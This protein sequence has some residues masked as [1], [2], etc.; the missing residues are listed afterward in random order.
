[1][2]EC[3]LINLA[4]TQHRQRDTRLASYLFYG[5]QIAGTI[6]AHDKEEVQISGIIGYGAAITAMPWL[7]TQPAKQFLTVAAAG[8]RLDLDP[9]E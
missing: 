5:H 3:Q 7:A 8:C 1:M 2:I 9:V 4:C 6:R